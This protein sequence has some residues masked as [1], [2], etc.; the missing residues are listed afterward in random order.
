[1]SSMPS[2]CAQCQSGASPFAWA[3]GFVLCVFLVDCAQNAGDM[4][5]MSDKLQIVFVKWGT[6]YTA[7]HVNGLLHAIR[8]RTGASLRVVCITD[9]GAGLDAQ[10]DVRPFPD[11]GVPFDRL[12]TSSCFGKISMF[13]QGI[14]KPGLPTLFFDLDTA[15]MGDVALLAGCL[16]RKRGLY[17]LKNHFLPIW[18]VDGLLRRLAPE[19]YYFGNSSIMAFYPEDYHFIARRFGEEYP[20]VLERAEKTHEP[21]HSSFRTD[22]RFISYVARETVRV[23]PGHLAA[24]FQDTY[25]TFAYWMSAL[26]DRWP[27]VRARRARRVALTFMGGQ[28]KPRRLAVI[29]EGEEIEYGPL[30]TRWNYPELRDY[31]A[32][33]AAAN[34]PQ[35][36]GSERKLDTE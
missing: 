3:G 30:K 16:E 23:F 29:Q 26:Q 24:R 1:M 5:P 6:A 19:K 31:W 10:I 27:G 20:G 14:L 36:N 33:V 15:V 13:A 35:D 34:L 25:M 9:D 7:A 11:L 28:T 22:D 17:M 4:V 2:V 12:T 21:V 8:S 18:R 32:G